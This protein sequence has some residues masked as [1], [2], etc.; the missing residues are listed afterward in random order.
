[1]YFTFNYS[2]TGLREATCDYWYAGLASSYPFGERG[3]HSIVKVLPKC[4]INLVIRRYDMLE[5][6]IFCIYTLRR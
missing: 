5:W 2:E 4:T 1:M 6:Y 3:G